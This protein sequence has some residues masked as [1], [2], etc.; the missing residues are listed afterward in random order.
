MG[1]RPAIAEEILVADVDLSRLRYD[2]PASARFATDLAAR[3][4]S[5]NRVAAVGLS[6]QSLMPGATN[7]IVLRPGESRPT[8]R[9]PDLVHVTPGWFDV[10]GLRPSAGRLLED[11]D[12]PTAVVVVD[13]DVAKQ[14]AGDRP[15]V[16]MPLRLQ[17]SG[18]RSTSVVAHVDVAGVVPNGMH[19][20]RPRRGDARIYV[21]LGTSLLYGEAFP[22]RFTVFARTALPAEVGRDLGRLITALEPRGVSFSVE[23]A[24]ALLEQDEDVRL[25]RA[26]AIG[27]G[28]AGLLAL[29][30]AAAGIYTAVSYSVSLQ[31]R[32]I[33]IRLAIGA[34]PAE[35]VALMFGRR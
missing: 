35:T 34:R 1:I 25:A 29:A 12:A 15:V 8:V 4:R 28:L 14:L 16:G 5:D 33:G 13:D 6:D 31:A 22:R 30:L 10:F 18:N 20:L 21:P 23:T 26:G 32:E 11:G 7:Q 9:P 27:V 2:G 19:R 3:I 17:Q 24:A